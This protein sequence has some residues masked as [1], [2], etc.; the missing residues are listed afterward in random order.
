MTR[1]LIVG[2]GSIGM[3][4]A[5]VIAGMGGQTAFVTARTDLDQ[6]TFASVADAVGGFEPDY[7]IVATETGMHTK[8]VG[9]LAAAGFSGRLLVEKPLAVPLADLSGF[10]F[11]GV[12]FNLRF[13]PVIIR[14]A[15]LLAP[16]QIYTVES[17]VGQ[18]LSTWRADRKVSDQYSA[19]RSRGGGVLRDL[20]HEWDYLSVLFGSC[21]GLIAR[22]GRLSEVTEDSDDAWGI[23]A[24]FDRAPV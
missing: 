3:R 12:G 19:S 16:E 10:S 21:R 20:S 11:V 1:A 23:L 4:H 17:Y 6:P 15:E 18:H 14:L 24:E 2:A 9:E 5:S 7:A 13:H 22:G 8:S